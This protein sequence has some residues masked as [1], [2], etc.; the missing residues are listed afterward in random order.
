M[1][2]RET[3]WWGMDWIHVAQNRDQWWAMVNMVMNLW[4]L[5]NFRKLMAKK[6]FTSQ[7]GLTTMD[8]KD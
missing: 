3:G 5:Y 6:V 2:L 4:V 7:D 1:D 8:Q